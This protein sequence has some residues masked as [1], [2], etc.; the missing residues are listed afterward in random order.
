MSHDFLTSLHSQVIA[1]SKEG[2]RA[3]AGGEPKPAVA[4]A[5]AV[6][7]HRTIGVSMSPGLHQRARSRAEAV[8]LSFSRYV[9][10]CLE[11]EL[12]GAKIESRFNHPE[13]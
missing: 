8:G 13:K 5:A 6:D 10:W 4:S 2:D 3:R 7:R 1:V 11:A 12:D 9:Q